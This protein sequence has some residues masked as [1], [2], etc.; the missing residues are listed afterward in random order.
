MNLL[1]FIKIS[2]AVMGVSISLQAHAEDLL[3]ARSPVVVEMFVSQACENCPK[4]TEYFA[5]L[6]ER[7][8]IVALSWHVDYWD[9]IVAG[10]NGRWSD[11]FADPSYADRQRNYNNNL[12]GRPIVFTPQVV[13]N[14]SKSVVGSHFAEVEEA[15]DTNLMPA[16]APSIRFQASKGEQ[17]EVALDN[18]SSDQSVFLV[19]FYK[20]A[21]THVKGG[22]NAGLTFKNANIVNEVKALDFLASPKRSVM[23][24]QP[25]DQMGCAV[26]VQAPGQG[27][28]LNAAYC[29]SKSAGAA[30]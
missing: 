16:V 15:I 27:E 13:V 2:A 4:A 17:I 25:M 21:E 12:R 9:N 23:I 10:R 7:P 3:E 29:P 18:L 14:G 6:A 30:Q 28:I 5:K 11:P 24:D 1:R 19:S 22:A 26:V 20:Q 8:D